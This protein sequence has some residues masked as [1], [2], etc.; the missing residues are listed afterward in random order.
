MDPITI[1]LAALVAGVAA[2]SQAT[3]AEAVKDAYHALKGLIEHKVQ[4]N[5]AAEN[6]LTKIEQ[7]PEVWEP[8]LRAGLIEAGAQ[9]DKDLL[10]AS[11]KLLALVD[12]K[13]FQMGKYQVQAENIQG[14]VQGDN[15]N[16][17]MNFGKSS[18]ET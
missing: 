11:H 6:A 9:H 4:G 12:A 17:T 13:G 3:A 16:V 2:G 15:A 8:S 1:I 18:S 5:V 7:K 10:S 14:S